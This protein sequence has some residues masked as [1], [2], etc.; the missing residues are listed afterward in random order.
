MDISVPVPSDD[1]RS[2]LHNHTYSG[3]S[4]RVRLTETAVGN[5]GNTL[6]TEQE[7]LITG[8]VNYAIS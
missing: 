5:N 8:I 2:I 3:L 7:Q 1:P 4:K 6:D